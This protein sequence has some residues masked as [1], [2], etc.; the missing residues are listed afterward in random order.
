LYPPAQRTGISTLNH[1]HFG[2]TS[3]DRFNRRFTM[4]EALDADLRRNPYSQGMA[5][6]ASFYNTARGMMYNDAVSQVFQFNATDEG[7]YGNTTAGRNLIIARNTV[8][9]KNGAVFVN[10]TVGEWDLHDTMFDTGRARNFYVLTN[11]L[12]RALG[13]LVEDLKASG[14]FDSTMIVLMGEF[15]RT[16]GN[17]NSRGGRDH[18]KDAMSVAM[19]GGGVKGGRVIGAKNGTGSAIVTPGWRGDRPIYTEDITSSIYSALGIDYTRSI[20]DTP[21]KR[22]Y[23]YV[24]GAAEGKYQ[25]IE[26]IWG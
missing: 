14:D 12:D 3:R 26:E 16:P 9:A 2:T 10:V 21:S 23:T 25:P 4:L 15:G 22:K 18:H 17:L 5:D 13:A 11:E 6:Y 1:D 8:R 24:P 20:A 19:L 7:R